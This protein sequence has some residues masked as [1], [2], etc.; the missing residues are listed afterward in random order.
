MREH[1]FFIIPLHVKN[2]CEAPEYM[3]M[4]MTSNF[5]VPRPCFFDAHFIVRRNDVIASQVPIPAAGHFSVVD[6]GKFETSFPW[7]KLHTSRTYKKVNNALVNEIQ[8]IAPECFCFASASA[9]AE[10]QLWQAYG[11]G[12]K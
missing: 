11:N 9:V 2:N 10:F 7:E 3:A 4:M 8:V 5:R 1:P 6:P 12:W